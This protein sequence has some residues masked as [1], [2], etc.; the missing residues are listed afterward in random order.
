M[1][2]V[3]EGTFKTISLFVMTIDYTYNSNLI[4]IAIAEDA[5]KTFSLFMIIWI[6]EATFKNV[7]ITCYTFW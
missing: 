3:T 4:I 1:L 7:I 6:T 5:I 2:L